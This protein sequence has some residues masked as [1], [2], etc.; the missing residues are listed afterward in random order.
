MGRQASVAVTVAVS[1]RTVTARLSVVLK[2]DFLVKTAGVRNSGCRTMDSDRY[3]NLLNLCSA[4]IGYISG[5]ISLGFMAEYFSSDEWE[6][7]RCHR[8]LGK[9][10][11]FRYSV[12]LEI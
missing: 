12:K 3:D 9:P 10:S 8:R 6:T 4:A 11:C 1:S 2:F 5:Q 7:I